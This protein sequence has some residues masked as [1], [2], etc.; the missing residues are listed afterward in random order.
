MQTGGG[1]YYSNSGQLRVQGNV[2]ENNTASSGA[3]GLELNLCSGALE[4][5]G[6]AKNK[7]PSLLLP[8]AAG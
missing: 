3:G 8:R 4:G 5:C 6:F 7:V 1:G 2:F